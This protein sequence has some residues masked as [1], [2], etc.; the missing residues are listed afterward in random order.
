M[1]ASK[2][3][4]PNQLKLFMTA[5]E[6]MNHPAG[7]SRDYVPMSQNPV[8]HERKLEEGMKGDARSTH[9]LFRPGEETGETLHDSIK[10]VGV[11]KPVE[12]HLQRGEDMP[13]ITDG[14]HRVAIANHLNPDMFVP[15][16][17]FG[18]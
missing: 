1:A 17:Y 11:K 6:L 5:G 15:I 7:D 14:H 8:V 12:L 3:I 9:G 10:R 16:M 4:N 18:R 13:T 2:H